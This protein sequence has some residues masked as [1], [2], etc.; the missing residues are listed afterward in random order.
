MIRHGVSDLG[1]LVWCLACVSE[2]EWGA[3]A[4]QLETHARPMDIGASVRATR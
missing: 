3:G 4:V 1:V 2:E